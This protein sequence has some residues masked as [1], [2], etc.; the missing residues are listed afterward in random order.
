MASE[1]RRALLSAG[2]AGKVDMFEIPSVWNL[3]ISTIVFFVTAWYVHRYLDEQGIPKGMTRGM[4]VF[5][6]A[7]LVSWAA[8]TAVDWTQEQVEGPQVERQTE[9]AVSQLLNAAGQLQ[10]Q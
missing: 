8:G 1:G 7:S 3:V 6:T 10:Q 9:G 4:L 5:V 2:V